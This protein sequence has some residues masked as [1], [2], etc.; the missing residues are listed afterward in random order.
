MEWEQPHIG[1]LLWSVTVF[2]REITRRYCPVGDVL[3]W[4]N[5]HI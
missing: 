5:E 3:A 1:R 4:E 2:G